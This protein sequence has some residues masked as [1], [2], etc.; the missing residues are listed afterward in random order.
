MI[1]NEQELAST[2]AQLSRLERALAALK[3]AVYPKSPERFF[4]MAE[5]YVDEIQKLRQEIDDFIGLTLL[6]QHE[7]RTTPQLDHRQPD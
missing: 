6:I 3:A 2:E 5:A 4:L 7:T 1:Y